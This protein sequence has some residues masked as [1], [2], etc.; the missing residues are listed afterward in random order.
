[1]PDT[2]AYSQLYF[3]A[4]TGLSPSR[5]FYIEDISVYLGSAFTSI[6]HFQFLELKYKMNIKIELGQKYLQFDGNYALDYCFIERVGYGFDDNGA[7]Y[8]I[9]NKH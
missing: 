6:E 5:N 8:F 4:E 9:N 2:S 1:M 3:W 7:Y